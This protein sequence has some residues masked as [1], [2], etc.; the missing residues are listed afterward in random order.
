MKR[1]LLFLVAVGLLPAQA[2]ALGI[3]RLTLES[4]LN[5]PFS[6]RI[7]L[8]S[9]T[10]EELDTL[11]VGLADSEAFARAGIERPY[12]LSGLRF[13][14]VETEAGAD[15]IRVSSSES[16]REP[17][18]NFLVEVSWSRGRLYR[19]YTVLLDP[20]FYD[21][22]AAPPAPVAQPQSAPAPLAAADPGDAYAAEP[23]AGFTAAPAFD[24]SEY[25]PTESTDTLWSI[26]GRTRPDES[27]SMQQ[28]MLALLRA[29][30][31]SFISDNV[32]GLRRGQVLR[33]P[34]IDEI[35]SVPADQAMAEIRSQ[36]AL[37]EDLRGTLA[38][39]PAS[40]P[41]SSV[42]GS[43]VSLPET[44]PQEAEPEL[45]LVAA[46]DTGAGA[47]Q[48]GNDAA[49]AA[50][51]EQLR[52]Q[53]AV[54]QEQ[55][56]AAAQENADLKDR[57]SESETII[58]DLKRLI[59]L[60]DDE[61]AALQ[62]QMAAAGE[63]PPE[64]VM[65]EPAA[66]EAPAAEDESAA[67]EPTA[68]EE[69]LPG[70]DEVAEEAASPAEPAPAPAP[71]SVA[72]PPAPAPVEPASPALLEQVSEFVR[73]N[74][75]LVGAGLGAVVLL[76]V[77]SFAVSRIR[78]RMEASAAG[79]AIE[80]FPDFAADEAGAEDEAPIG[81]EDVTNVRGDAAAAAPAAA[82]PAAAKAK[83]AVSED[84]TVFALP[85]EPKAKAAA[86]P[87]AAAEPAP[88]APAEDPLAEV[89]VFLAYEHYDQA[90]EFVRDAI[91][92]EP[93]NLD[94]H[95]KL[96][97][98][99]YAAGERRKYEEA[100][101][102]LHDKVDGAGPYWDNALVMWQDM[103]P[104][105][106]LFAAGGAEE[107]AAPARTATGGGLLDLTAAASSGDAGLDFDLGE[108]T[109]QPA[110]AASQEEPMLDITAGSE[111]AAA[112]EQ[113]AS[114][115]SDMLDV[116][117]A[118]GLETEDAGLNLEPESAG[119][120][121]L[122]L[123]GGSE[124]AAEEAAGD[125]LLDVSATGGGLL[126]VTAHTDVG[127]QGLDEDP[128][129]V[130]S[131]AASARGGSSLLDM[132]SE[133]A[134]ADDHSLDFNLDLPDAPAADGEDTAQEADSGNVIEFESSGGGLELELDADSAPAGTDETSLG[135]GL[136]LDAGDDAGEIELDMEATIAEDNDAAGGLELDL[137]IDDG[138]GETA[139][140]DVD[141]EGTVEIPKLE[142]ELDDD[143]DDDDEDHTV[144]VP[145]SGDAQEQTAEDEIATKLDLAKAYVE[146]GDKDSA[147]GI[148][149]QVLADGNDQQK[150]KAQELIRQM[151]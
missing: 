102:V 139:A 115:G 20:P 67:P 112:L 58:A 94:F 86:K 92:R 59:S 108:A 131:T 51:G 80:D 6:A 107:E 148:L 106:A 1:I 137:S 66:D 87:A 17:F 50:G 124:P 21:A 123:T 97:E 146:L 30:P 48:G 3:G 122:D 32:N 28:M 117:A 37:W 127:S 95:A 144:F 85:P 99:F 16:I 14:L 133:E 5:E 142:L 132:P 81:S 22:A 140:E 25:G 71:Q 7:E 69:L 138:A 44:L 100:A 83:P 84:S 45:R 10:R 57:L 63:A 8:L 111:D 26:A 135:G 46:A 15:H 149:D 103:S 121:V 38:A 43:T 150:R 88:S 35:N 125:D 119:D 105:R 64:E 36:Y 96:L 74:L 40:Q 70:E 113:T 104:N 52:N 116:T 77:G 47:G 61:L 76:L 9:V 101:K 82:A 73:G 120:G 98:V 130:T 55:M 136:E 56:T 93:D 114:E 29:N 60:K 89:N 143:D 11:N 41:A 110:A 42:A 19:E 129:D 13:E 134:P 118:V 53:L 54:A 109:A 65:P 2:H 34:G 18:L 78:S 79:A 91:E 49:G 75:L 31:E 27:V 62:Q 39:S 128:L 145:R 90:E 151:S 33:I 72:A 126:D 12:V 24:G 4:A 23:A 147:K 141:M 68:G